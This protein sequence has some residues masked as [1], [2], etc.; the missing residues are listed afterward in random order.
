MWPWGHLA[1]AYLVYTMYCHA[2]DGRPPRGL[3]ALALAFGSQLPDLIDKPLAW[4]LGVL[5]GGR[6][7]AHSVVGAALVLS[8]VVVAVRRTGHRA[9]GP[10]VAIGYGVHLLTDL[11]P[12]VLTGDLREA[13]FLAWPLLTPP[14]YETPASLAA[15]FLRYSM[16]TAEWIQLGLVAVALGIWLRDGHPG[17]GTVRRGLARIGVSRDIRG[18]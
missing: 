14:D 1:V 2:R 6:T 17:L 16:G 18:R 15:G 8:V 7:L 11:P 5:P 12:A 9:V 4:S 13:T 3:P 10:A